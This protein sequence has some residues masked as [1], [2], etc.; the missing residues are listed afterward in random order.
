MIKKDK[1]NL[2]ANKLYELDEIMSNHQVASSSEFKE[3]KEACE[4]LLENICGKDSSIYKKFTSIIYTPRTI[5]TVFKLDGSKSSHS[6]DYI[7]TFQN[8][9]K[10]A[11]S[12]LKSALIDIDLRLEDDFVYSPIETINN[13]CIQFK[14]VAKQLE[15]R[16]NSR[17]TLLIKDEY[18]V[19]DLF[20]ALLKLFFEDIRPEEYSP[21]IAGNSTRIDFVLKKEKIAIELKKTRNNL[22]NKEITSELADDI[23]RY[24]SHK[25][26]KLLICFV[27]DVDGFISNPYGLE[28]D[29]NQEHEDLSVRVFVYPK[30]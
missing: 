13:I 14:K 11:K 20:H 29:L 28:N 12:I 26:C 8:G 19:Q 2:V 30:V 24:R 22:K 25:D 1:K 23:L 3:W 6:S 21:S 4:V 27:Y 18:D 16:Y 10:S 9:I 17:D 5:T 7:L 15:K